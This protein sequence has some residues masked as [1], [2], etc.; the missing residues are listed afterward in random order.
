MHEL[1]IERLC[2]FGMPPVEMVNLAADLGCRHVGIGQTAMLYY[3]PDGYPDWSLRDDPSLRRDLIAVMRERDVGIA[4]LDAIALSPATG[5]A[6]HAADLDMLCELGGRRINAVSQER[7]RT[8]AFDGFAELAQMAGERGIE[9]VIEIGPG[10][11]R[12]LEKALAA[13]AHVD[14][15]NFRLLV[16]TM[17]YF[18]LGGTMADLAAI[19]P[20]L[21]GYVQLCDVPP[22]PAFA[23]Y[24]EEA[25]HERLVP[26]DGALPLRAF[27][28]IVPQDVIV[29][30]EVPQR[31]LAEAGIGPW[32]RIARCL[33]G[34]RALLPSQS[35]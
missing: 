8:R 4:L 10:P 3:N 29:S 33:E 20:A 11:V 2:T 7:D 32:E 34:A 25:L 23:S 31:S 16:D 27:L 28:A 22:E 14:R 6:E 35:V 13:V 15:P 5:I 24:M 17:H 1:G 30:V 18:R 26:G 19:D 21:I 9:V 12:N